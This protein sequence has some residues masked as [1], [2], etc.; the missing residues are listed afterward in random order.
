MSQVVRLFSVYTCTAW[1]LVFSLQGTQKLSPRWIWTF[2]KCNNLPPLHPQ[3][4]LHP[5]CQ[6]WNSSLQ[7]FPNYLLRKC[8]L[9]LA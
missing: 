1:F 7:S 5:L 4:L 9:W 3:V 6:T 2:L 8:Y